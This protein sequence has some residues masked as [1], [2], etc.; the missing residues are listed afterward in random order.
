M[1]SR[2]KRWQQQQIDLGLC[3]YGCG[4]A[5][6]ALAFSCDVCAEKA[7][8]RRRKKDGEPS[9]PGRQGRPRIP[10]IGA[11]LDAAELRVVAARAD[12]ARAKQRLQSALDALAKSRVKHK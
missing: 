9:A 5:R 6:G 8:A 10:R 4:R 2:Q 1:T 7:N 12:V 11:A 3:G